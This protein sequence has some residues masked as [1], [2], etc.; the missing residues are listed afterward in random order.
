MTSIESLYKVFKQKYDV[1]KEKF[2]TNPTVST[3]NHMVT[4]IKKVGNFLK[5]DFY[6]SKCPSKQTSDKVELL[7]SIFALWAIIKAEKNDNEV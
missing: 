3:I 7:A 6:Q 2:K 4:E 1:H 5:D